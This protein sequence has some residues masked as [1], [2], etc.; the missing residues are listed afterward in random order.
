MTDIGAVKQVGCSDIDRLAHTKDFLKLDNGVAF[1][2]EDES[3][4]EIRRVGRQVVQ[5]QGPFVGAEQG[6]VDVGEV[7][8]VAKSEE[9]EEDD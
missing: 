9:E 7:L 1:S 3:A 8:S 5:V 6:G 2:F 4:P